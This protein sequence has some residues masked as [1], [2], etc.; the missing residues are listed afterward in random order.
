VA[1]L[2][3]IDPFGQSLRLVR[4]EMNNIHVFWQPLGYSS[5]NAQNAL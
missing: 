3:L 2:P 5:N 1:P 4:F